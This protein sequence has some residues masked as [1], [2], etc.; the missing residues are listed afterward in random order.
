MPKLWL[1]NAVWC[2]ESSAFP[3][4]ND[5]DRRGIQAEVAMMIQIRRLHPKTDSSPRSRLPTALL[6]TLAAAQHYSCSCLTVECQVWCLYYSIGLNTQPQGFF[7]DK[8][9]GGEE[10]A[11]AQMKTIKFRAQS[12][13]QLL[14]N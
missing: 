6:A 5:K 8:H 1:E 7:H 4:D 13:F 11:N 10:D 9:S 14:F 12:G 3:A 2:R